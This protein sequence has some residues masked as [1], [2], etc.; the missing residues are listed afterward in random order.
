MS[1][2]ARN[3]SARYGAVAMT[4]HWIIAAL[5]I[6][7]LYLGLG[8]DDYARGDPMKF[9]VIGLHKSIGLT[10][11][12]LSVLRL[13]WRLINP[14]PPAPPGLPRWM[15]IAGRSMHYLF[16]ALIV[17]I[18]LAGWMMVSAGAMGH[19]TPVFGQ[20]GIPHL[21]DW[22]AFPWLSDLTRSQAHPYHETFQS[23]H[24]VL[25]WSM[26]GLIPLHIGAAPYHHY[27]RGDN[28]LLRMLPGLKLRSG[29]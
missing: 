20:F 28:V 4:L 10:V 24:V 5:I 14:A 18:P 27:F 25:A 16:Y 8:F 23:I 13:V 11:L 9:Q 19:G 29:V 22:P 7:N 2:S 1:T 3:P 26:L 15:H 12:T 6:L 17:A 21:F